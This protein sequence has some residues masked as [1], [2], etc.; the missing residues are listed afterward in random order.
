MFVQYV[1]TIISYDMSRSSAAGSLGV[2]Y[3]T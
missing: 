3:A 2:R 1:K